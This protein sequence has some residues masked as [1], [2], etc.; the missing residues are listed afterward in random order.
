MIKS[1]TTVKPINLRGNTMSKQ[2]DWDV[3][4]GWEK[5]IKVDLGSVGPSHVR[6]SHWTHKERDIVARKVHESTLISR[7]HGPHSRRMGDW[8]KENAPIMTDFARDGKPMPDWAHAE[9]RESGVPE[10]V[11][12]VWKREDPDDFA[13]LGDW[14]YDPP[15]PWTDKGE[16]PAWSARPKEPDHNPNTEIQ[17]FLPQDLQ[18]RNGNLLFPVMDIVY[19]D[20]KDELLGM[21]ESKDPTRGGWVTMKVLEAKGADYVETCRDA[22]DLHFVVPLSYNIQKE[23]YASFKLYFRKSNGGM[24]RP[25]HIDLTRD[26]PVNPE[27]TGSMHS[28]YGGVVSYQT[29]ANGDHVASDGTVISTAESRAKEDVP[30]WR[31]FELGR[32]EEVDHVIVPG[33]NALPKDIEQY[34]ENVKLT[35]R[36]KVQPQAKPDRIMPDDPNYTPLE[37]ALSWA[38][39]TH[40][41]P[42][43]Q[44]RWNGVAE[45]L[46]GDTGYE[47]M[48]MSEVR[49]N[50]ERFNRNARWTMALE[51]LKEYEMI[52]GPRGAKGKKGISG[53]PGDSGERGLSGIPT[54][55][56]VESLGM[57]TDRDPIEDAN[58]YR[59]AV[60]L[61]PVDEK[62]SQVDKL[63]EALLDINERDDVVVKKLDAGKLKEIAA[64]ER[65][66]EKDMHHYH[67]APPVQGH[68]TVEE[69]E[70]MNGSKPVIASVE[71]W[72]MRYIIDGQLDEPLYQVEGEC[73]EPTRFFVYE[74]GMYIDV[75]KDKQRE[76]AKPAIEEAVAEL[77][78]TNDR[79]SIVDILT[80]LFTK[81]F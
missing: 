75:T 38:M 1:Y 25:E 66:R 74:D 33:P 42:T 79:D 19:P 73:P 46:G 34:G 41:G 60:G 69:Y 64:K 22:R 39:E 6:W 21:V 30:Q 37:K 77:A 47:A 11:K 67:S 35:K 63:E 48:S 7:E 70:R 2:R 26:I 62:A 55:A 36:H 10:Y 14:A 54:K 29:K 12:V 23:T 16:E 15:A 51:A 17:R 52:H 18:W 24:Q 4:T 27:Y 31:K 71:G 44:E 50:W 45:A 80:K 72:E 78:E 32:L 76:D 43:H 58:R 3:V 56:Y 61:P 13:S 68:Y 59:E 9:Y 65:Q 5:R 8:A 28:K 53:P 20:G 40:H 57:S 81:L 49:A